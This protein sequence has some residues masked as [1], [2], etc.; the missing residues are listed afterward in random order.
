M[1]R[2]IARTPMG[3][4]NTWGALPAKQPVLMNYVT[5][6]QFMFVVTIMGK[7]AD[8]FSFSGDNIS[9]RN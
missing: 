7:G 9:I 8:K 2:S 1:F 6:I 4:F 3:L 5:V